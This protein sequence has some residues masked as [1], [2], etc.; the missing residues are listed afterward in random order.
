MRHIGRCVFI[1][2]CRLLLF[3]LPAAAK[4][5]LHAAMHRMQNSAIIRIN[6]I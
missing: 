6:E 3:G 5:S 2:K 1:S 4:S